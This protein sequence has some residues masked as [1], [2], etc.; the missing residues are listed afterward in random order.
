MVDTSSACDERVG[1]Q[2]AAALSLCGDQLTGEEAAAAGLA[3][4]CLPTD[5][6]VATA[7]RYAAPGREPSPELVRRAKD[8]LDRSGP[9]VDP[10]D[11][12]GRSSARPR[13]GRWPSR[14]SPNG[15]PRSGPGSAER[16]A[17]RL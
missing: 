3:W 17:D 10:A 8:S 16:E 2:G 14:S 4:R 11:G 9:G 7:E 12:P 1:R 13:S 15:S 5:E 6:L